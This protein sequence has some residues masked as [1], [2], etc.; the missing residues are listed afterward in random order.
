MQRLNSK[1]LSACLVSATLTASAQTTWTGD[2]SSDTTTGGNWTDGAPAY[3]GT[4]I[5]DDASTVPNQPVANGNNTEVSLVF[6]TAGWTVGTNGDSTWGLAQIDSSGAGV[7]EIAVDT[8][9]RRSYTRTIS[10]G[11]TLLMSG[12]IQQNGV[13][14]FDGGGVF[15]GTGTNTSTSNFNFQLYTVN[16]TTAWFTNDLYL[17]GNN[18]GLTDA[19]STVGLGGTLT[20]YQYQTA[21]AGDGTIQIGGDGVYA[22]AVGSL[23]ILSG[24]GTNYFNFAMNANTTLQMDIGATAGVNDNVTVNSSGGTFNLG[25]ALL[26]L[27]GPANPEDG[28]YRIVNTV[29][30]SS[31]SNTFGSV[32]YNGAT[33]DP[34]NLDVIY[35]ADYVDVAITGIIPEPGQYALLGGLLAIAAAVLR[36]RRD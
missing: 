36:R 3:Q 8:F 32:T 30:S 21:Q 10:T 22:P 5:F 25:G 19:T 2:I 23:E 1:I 15:I 12:N 17:G 35:G 24:N 11:N 26:D 6:N 16:G 33:Y 28:L 18:A 7:N 27:V 31:F 34:S 4:A 13:M 14:T 20:G 9:D 29:G